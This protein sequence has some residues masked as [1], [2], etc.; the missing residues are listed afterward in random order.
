MVAHLSRGVPPRD[1]DRPRLSDFCKEVL[2]TSEGFYAVDVTDE[3]LC[4]VG[5]PVDVRKKTLEGVV[6]VRH[7]YN[8]ISEKMQKGPSALSMKYLM[9]LKQFAWLLSEDEK[10]KVREWVAAVAKHYT[11][12]DG[13]LSLTETAA[14][15]L[16]SSMA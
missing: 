2:K 9:P 5:K 12:K 8:N 15:D 1:N 11:L 16:A 13:Q 3:V 7:T 4:D 10:L 14:D 6:A